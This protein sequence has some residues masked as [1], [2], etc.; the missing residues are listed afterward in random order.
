MPKLIRK[1]LSALAVK[2]E[3]RKGWY[4]D[5]G[6]LYLQVSSNGAKS[7]LFRY[8]IEGRARAMG[9]GSVELMSLVDAR[10]RALGLRRLLRDGVDPLEHRRSAKDAA[11]LEAASAT[12]FGDCARAYVAAHRPTWRGLRHA[13]AWE[14]SLSNH[15]ALLGPLPITAIDLAHVVKVLEPIWLSKRNTAARVRARIERVLDWATVRGFRKGDNPARW[16]G[17]LDHLLPAQSA[18]VHHHA[19]LP[20][21]EVA[22]FVATVRER[23]EVSARAFEFLIL[24]AART[25]EVLNATWGELDAAR[26]IWT[27]SAKRMKAA[28]EH[29]V[30]LSD[31]ARTII[32]EMEKRAGTTT[33]TGAFVFPAAASGAAYSGTTLLMLLRR[34]GRGNLTAHG[35]R[36]TFRDWAAERTNYPREVCEQALA[37]AI[38]DKVEAAYRR[39]DLFEKRRRLMQAWARWCSSPQPAGELVALSPSRTA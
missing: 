9:L 20:Y 14:A 33:P 6:G 11:R 16:T 18:T 21:A 28:R 1:Q 7:W 15:A 4:A 22:G 2:A 17:H 10:E 36:S 24:T 27:I 26:R 25:S 12:T 29:R 38:G 30:P 19:A 37:H 31:R 3:R 13:E 32:L 39:G 34:M 5:G 35:F 23:D 8:S